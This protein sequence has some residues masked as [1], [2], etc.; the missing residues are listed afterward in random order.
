MFGWEF[1]PFNRGGL[2]TACYGLTKGLNSQGVKVTFVVPRGQPHSSAQLNLIVADNLYVGNEKLKF[3]LINSMLKAYMSE[4]EYDIQK[5]KLFQSHDSCQGEIY[6]KNLYEEVERYSE[7]AKVIAKFED[8]DVIHAHDW[9]SFKAGIK[10]KKA[11][12]KPLVVHVHA[13]EFDRTGG[14]PNQLVYNIEREGMHAADS[15]IAVSNYTKDKIVNHYGIDKNK[16]HV[17]HNAILKENRKSEFEKKLTNKT[18]LFL[19]RL[20]LQKGPDYFI[21]VANRVLQHDPDVRFIVAGSGDMYGKMI[22]KVAEYNI[23]SKV[24][25]TGHLSGDDVNKAYRMA[26]LFIMPSVSEPFGITPLEALKNNTPVI[27]SKQSGVS[28]VLTNALKVDFWDIDEM[29]NKTLSVLNYSS[30]KETLTDE[31]VSEIDQMD[32]TDAAI[33]CINVYNQV[34]MGY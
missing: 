23:G 32:W 13:T 4:E 21:E 29:V 7:K 2:G 17:V 26:D 10:A 22:N 30:L 9:M 16:V 14:H 12:G 15:I 20:T 11:S 8:F 6:G 19:G 33:K 5:T 31:G 18:V 27:I 1:P 28:E 25:F 24:L 34:T 3:K